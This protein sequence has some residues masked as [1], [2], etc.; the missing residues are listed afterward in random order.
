MPRAR[1]HLVCV[2]DTPYYHVFSRCVRRAFL[3]GVDHASG[4]SYEHRRAW[5]E[6]RIRVLSSLF[7]IDL[8]AYAV[9]SNHYHLVV[10]L[11][12]D[13]AKGWSDDEVLQRWTS[14]FRGPLLVQRYRAGVALSAAEQ[15]TVRAT[16]SVYRQRLGDLSWF[17]KCLNE[18][19]ARQANAEDRCTGHFWEARFQSQALRSER[20]LLAAMAYVDLNPVRARMAPTPEDSEYTSIRM[21]IR[22]DDGPQ[23]PYGLVARVLERRELHHFETA[24]RPL[25]GF[26]DTVNQIEGSQP[27]AETLP[28]RAP[29]YLQ[30]VDAT[31][32]LL[33]PG[34]HGRIDASVTPILDRLGLSS[35]EWVQA[36]TGFRQHYR[37]G[38][39]RLKP[40]G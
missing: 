13:E 30:L 3:C 16:A 38:D 25:L 18:P 33:V 15:D 32:R 10:K 26:S 35:S 1:K 20:A 40:T 27:S 36:S 39:L 8:C 19:I 28:I 17:M 11:N 31:G 24:I 7:S 4:K 14:L 29:D 6:D 2:A 37:N 5:I 21:R 9:M 12:P 22:G 34:K 23:G